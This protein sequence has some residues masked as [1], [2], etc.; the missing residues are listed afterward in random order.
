MPHALTFWARSLWRIERKIMGCRLG[1]GYARGGAH[2]LAAKIFWGVSACIK[3]HHDALANLEGG[4]DRLLK[5]LSVSLV[6]PTVWFMDSQPINYKFNEMHLVSIDLHV[7]DN[8]TDF[9]IYTDIYK[10]AFGDTLKQFLI[11][12]LTAFDKRGE[13]RYAMTIESRLYH[14][15][16]LTF[17]IFH[18]FLTRLIRTRLTGTRIEQTQKIVDLRYSANSR[19]RILIRCLLLNRD[20]RAKAGNLVNIRALR[21][22]EKLTGI[23][24]ESLNIATL[25]LSINGIKCERRLSA[26]AHACE[27]NKTIPRN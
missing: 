15:E 20:D 12:T 13:K 14:V 7:W 2:Q 1:I 3:D 10:S 11:M 5:P 9:T 22:S 23:G 27:D 18:H 8:L 25:P 17:G 21:T 4:L 6:S 19:A 24:G 26:T 16:N